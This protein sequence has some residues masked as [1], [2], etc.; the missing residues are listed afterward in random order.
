MN[1]TRK[2]RKELM[3]FSFLLPSLLVFVLI[4]LLPLIEGVQFTFTD[5]DGI[6]ATKN[7][8]GFHNYFT[9]FH[10][11]DLLVPIRNTAIFTV[12][13]V[14]LV[15]AV[16]LG[17]ALLVNHEFRGINIA[18]SILFMPLVISLVLTSQ[19]W[20]YVYNDFFSLIHLENPLVNK[21][22]VMLG[23]CGMCVWKESGL[24]MMVYLAGLKGIPQ[25]VEEAAIMDGASKWQRFRYVTIPFLAPAF[26]Y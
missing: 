13:T 15:N 1:R 20:M 17:L 22:L 9:V 11:R 21:K 26:T 24:A 5:W 7:F 16:G 2:L 6:S 4:I 23:L 14:I 19:M 18:K 25:D 12:V 10:D 8:V 3:D